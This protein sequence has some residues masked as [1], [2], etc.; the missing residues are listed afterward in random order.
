[1]LAR[2]RPEI[3]P[4]F[5]S[6]T[7]VVIAS[8]IR[9]SYFS[10]AYGAIYLDAAYLALSPEQQASITDEEDYRSGFGSELQ[11]RM[12]WRM[13]RDNRWI[14]AHRDADRSRRIEDLIPFLGF[15]LFHEL[16]HAVDWMPPGEIASLS[17]DQ[18]PYQ[19]VDARLSRS[20]SNAY[21]LTSQVMKDLAKVSFHGTGSTAT[22]RALEPDDLIDEFAPDGATQY[23]SYSTVREDF[24]TLFDNVMM[25]FTFGI[26]R[27]VGITDVPASGVRSN[28]VVAWGQRGRITDTAVINRVRAA[29]RGV[30]ANNSAIRDGVEAYLD[31]LAA[32]KSLRAGETWGENV[33]L[34]VPGGQTGQGSQ[35]EALE[36]DLLRR[37]SIY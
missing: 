24:A 4:L 17:L 15:L 35:G 22:Q 11:F 33:V 2:M 18:K 20:V 28:G 16:A 34:D 23:Y 3:L 37:R 30:Y 9:P 19:V 25:R 27:D 36:D 10:A 6:V 1:M 26:A 8:D 29:V 14:L 13:V 21:P 5:R 31:G 7:V 12:P 32:P